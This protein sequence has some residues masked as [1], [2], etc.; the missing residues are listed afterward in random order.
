MFLKYVC[1]QILDIKIPSEMKPPQECIHSYD[2]WHLSILSALGGMQL[3]STSLESEYKRT[4]QIT[5]YRYFIN[6][7]RFYVTVSN[8]TTKRAKKGRCIRTQKAEK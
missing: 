6:S 1:Q 2:L 7:D 3:V 5:P 8:V 4:L